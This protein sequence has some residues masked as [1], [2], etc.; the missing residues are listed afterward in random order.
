MGEIRQREREISEKD[1]GGG[2]GGV[3]SMRIEMSRWSLQ[4][5]MSG[6]ACKLLLFTSAADSMEIN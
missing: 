2:G 4:E 6:S 3:E 1:C 5:E